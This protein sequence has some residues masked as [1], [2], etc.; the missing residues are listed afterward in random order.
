MATENRLRFIRPKQEV[1]QE[2][3]GRKSEVSKGTLA[4]IENG[5]TVPAVRALEVLSEALGTPLEQLSDE[6]GQSPSF[7]NLPNRLS[8]DDIVRVKFR[9]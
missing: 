2:A 6:N 1:S 8:C 5:H 9:K 7:P 4:F 3:P